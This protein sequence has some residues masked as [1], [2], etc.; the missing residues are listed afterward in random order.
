MRQLTSAAAGEVY[1]RYAADG[2]SV[3]FHTWNSP[4][5]IG[6]YNG[7]ADRQH[8]RHSATARWMKRSPI[9]RPDGKLLAFVRADPDAERIYVA[10]VVGGVA[11][12]LRSSRGTIPRWSPDGTTIAFA[13]DRGY[14]GGIFIIR[15]DGTGERQLTKEGGWPVWWPDGS[16]IGY[17]VAGPDG[18][19]EIRV[20]S[21]GGGAT[22]RLDRVRR[23]GVNHPFAVFQDGQR[24]VAETRDYVSDEIWV[25]QP[26]R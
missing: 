12:R 5:R 17:L 26:Q 23:V 25:I 10:P 15:S 2:A 22:R 3:Y 4:R 14:A 13:S 20:V 24:L 8:G 11:R 16:Q 19:N 6:R 7:P 9:P 21:L 1:P 18:N